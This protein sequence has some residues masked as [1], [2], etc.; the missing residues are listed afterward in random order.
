MTQ[1]LLSRL[2]IISS[3]INSVKIKCILEKFVINITY[4]VYCNTFSAEDCI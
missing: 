3:K 2:S 1:R 4:A